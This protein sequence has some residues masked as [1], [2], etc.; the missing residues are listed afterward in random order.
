MSR[1]DEVL[2]QSNEAQFRHAN[3]HIH[4]L[5]PGGSYDAEDGTMTP[6]AIVDLALAE[7][8]Q[9]LSTTNPQCVLS[10]CGIRHLG[11]FTFEASLDRAASGTRRNGKR[12]PRAEGG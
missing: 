1:L 4:S 9:V 7:N 6:A 11:V 10:V 2:D 8:L 5:G 3:L 12:T